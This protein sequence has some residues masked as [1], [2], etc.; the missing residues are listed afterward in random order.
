MAQEI[1]RS[2]A[3]F[4]TEEY[5]IYT[6]WG[7]TWDNHTQT[8]TKPI[9]SFDLTNLREALAWASLR[10]LVFEA[11]RAVSPLELK[12][13]LVLIYQFLSTNPD[14]TWVGAAEILPEYDPEHNE[15]IETTELVVRFCPAGE[16]MV[17]LIV[18]KDDEDLYD[19]VLPLGDPKV[20]APALEI[21]RRHW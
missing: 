19:E 5:G 1:F 2:A 10:T 15:P 18:E 21:V 11:R 13:R 6:L 17:Q 14:M 7:Y 16:G 20:L 9:K 8:A 4:I 3:C 12:D